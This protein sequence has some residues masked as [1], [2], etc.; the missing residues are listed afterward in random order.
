MDW[1]RPIFPVVCAV[2]VLTACGEGR[3]DRELEVE[4]CATVAGLATE[5]YGEITVIR[6]RHWVLENVRTVQLN[7]EYPPEVT[8]FRTGHIVCAYD[9]NLSVRAD[10]D[11]VPKALTVYFKGRYLSGDELKYVNTSL[12]RP[13]PKFKVIP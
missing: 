2:A 1:K 5:T 12:F 8:E 9:F 10:A 13:V 3:R 7:F 4:H 6:V 11:R